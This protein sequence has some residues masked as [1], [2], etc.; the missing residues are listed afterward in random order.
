[1]ND[2][3]VSIIIP[4][5]N[6]EPYLRQCLDSVCNQTFKDIEIICINDC[7]IDNSL[8]ILEEYQK[9]DNRIKITDLKENKGVSYSRN[10]GL[11]LAKAEYVTFVDSDD[12][13]SSNY[14]E[15]LY[16][17]IKKFDYDILCCDFF[18]YYN[19]NSA[20][21]LEQKSFCYNTDFNTVQSKQ[22][23]LTYRLIWS[24]WAKIYKRDF[25]EKNKIFFKRRT[26]EDILFIYEI[27]LVSNKVKFINES[28]YFYRQDRKSS[29]MSNKTGRFYSCI[30]LLYDIKNLLIQKQVFETY[31]QQF[32][33][34]GFLLLAAELEVIN[35]P[36]ETIKQ[37]IMSLKKNLFVKNSIKIKTYDKFPYKIRLFIFYFCFKH[38]IN[39]GSIGKTLRKLYSFV[40][41]QNFNAK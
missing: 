16:N 8:K 31:E 24:S 3:K 41:R 14:T 19:E 1:M 40:K 12:F 11:K 13:V 25:L 4:V 22:K 33:S 17:N 36:D 10:I 29:I 5:Y 27:I 26:M 6:V 7:S 20:K 34:Y 21:H 15:I 18:L 35:L 39:Y 2:I 38:N 9:K 37:A 23:L 28:I 30:E 32:Y